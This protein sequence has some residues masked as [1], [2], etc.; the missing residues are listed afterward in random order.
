MLK[1]KNLENCSLNLFEMINKSSKI[2]LSF[3]GCA[4]IALVLIQLYW[5]DNAIKLKQ[6]EF[7]RGVTETLNQFVAELEKEEA[8]DRLKSHQQG[9]FLFINTDSISSNVAVPDTGYDVMYVKE[10]KKENDQIEINIIEDHHGE[11]ISKKIVKEISS[12]DDDSIIDLI[13]EKIKLNTNELNEEIILEKVP[14]QVDSIIQKR[15]RKKTAVIGDIVKNLI[16]I[17]IYESIEERLSKF[18]FDKKINEK[19][20][21]NGIASVLNYGVFDNSNKMVLSNLIKNETNNELLNSKFK[22]RLFPNDVIGK[23]NMLIVDFPDQTTFVLQQMWSVLLL[24]VV[25]L[26]SIIF[27][28]VYTVVT[29]VRQKKLS[30]MKNDFINNITHELKTPIS[31]ISLACQSL[32][33]KSINK[34]EQKVNKYVKMI[35]EENSR[36]G[37]LVENVLQTAVYD[38]GKFNLR[39]EKLNLKS[40]LIEAISNIKNQVQEKNGEI[41]FNFQL[42]DDYLIETD[43]IHFVNIITNLLDNA[44]KYS[45]EFPK[46][47]IE[48][49]KSK[50]EIEIS[51]SDNG[52]GIHKEHQKR[53]FDSLYRIPTGDIY[54]TKGF[55]LGLNYVKNVVEKMNWKIKVSSQI[56]KGSSF[57]ITILEKI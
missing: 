32:A 37:S 3:V 42:N 10:V 41:D 44:N 31:T 47:M 55:G 4:V 5:I 34:D 25:V 6:K 54:N 24:S 9:K 15:V 40:L 7:E 8:V 19:F 57:I 39:I 20:I 16:E 18:D 11:R 14:H 28:F 51:V 30:E 33:D 46:I 12:T 2:L 1:F 38:K 27:G 29:I 56:N 22:T 36:L 45:N 53:I 49:I 21:D 48:V 13:E 52:I 43:A 50:N 26:I 35:S 23:D 17:D